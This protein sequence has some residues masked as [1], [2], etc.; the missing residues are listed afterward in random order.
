MNLVLKHKFRILFKEN[1]WGN[2][3]LAL[4]MINFKRMKKNWVPKWN[5]RWIWPLKLKSIMRL[6]YG[7][8]TNGTLSWHSL[9][10]L[11]KRRPKLRLK[12]PVWYHQ[13]LWK[14]QIQEIYLVPQ[15]EKILAK[16]SL[17]STQWSYLKP[18]ILT[19]I[20]KWIWSQILKAKTWIIMP[21]IIASPKK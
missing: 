20:P 4:K 17:S 16:V 1:R 2:F 18:K 21:K 11:R 7:K 5:N 12:F 8:N 13:R 19:W 14:R 10:I 6:A 3:I 15:S 9:E